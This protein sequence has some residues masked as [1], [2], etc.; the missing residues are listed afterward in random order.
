MV[1][2]QAGIGLGL[3]PPRSAPTVRVALSFGLDTAADLQPTP[4]GLGRLRS[5]AITRSR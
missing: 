5:V 2:G 3:A 1:A 4:T